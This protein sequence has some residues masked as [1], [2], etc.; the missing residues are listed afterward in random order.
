MTS[1]IGRIKLR[2]CPTTVTVRTFAEKKE[3]ERVQTTPK[4]L[5]GMKHMNPTTPLLNY[6]NLCFDIVSGVFINLLNKLVWSMTNQPLTTEEVARQKFLPN[7]ST[8]SSIQ[9]MNNK[10]FT[11][12]NHLSFRFT[13]YF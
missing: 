2:T 9:E 3:R 4:Q 12:E 6:K 13:V 5:V 11:C 10:F 1:V 7:V 8:H